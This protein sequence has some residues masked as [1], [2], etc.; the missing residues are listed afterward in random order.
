MKEA[1]KI[2]NVIKKR[3]ELLALTQRD[4]AKAVGI[5]ASY[6]SYLENDERTCVW[7]IVDFA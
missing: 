2:G 6:I 4:V 7:R 5:K 3:R 1:T